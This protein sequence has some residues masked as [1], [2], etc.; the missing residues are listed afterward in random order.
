MSDAGVRKIEGEADISM[1]VQALATVLV[2]FMDLDSVIYRSDVKL[3]A[4]YEQLKKV[5]VKKPFFMNDD[6]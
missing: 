1:S 3:N 2:G 5:F 6:F 4:N